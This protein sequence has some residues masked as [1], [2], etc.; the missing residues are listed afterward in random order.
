MDMSPFW[1]QVIGKLSPAQVASKHPEAFAAAQDVVS[2]MQKE[3]AYDV[4][5]AIGP[6]GCT[7]PEDEEAYGDDEDGEVDMPSLS[8][9]TSLM[10]YVP[11]IDQLYLWNDSK[12]WICWNY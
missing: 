3:W 7:S 2:G 12:S 11:D 6:S 5:P 9:D 4:I 8:G 10:M 1:N